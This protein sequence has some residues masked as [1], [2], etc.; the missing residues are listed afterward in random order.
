MTKGDMK[1]KIAS[2]LKENHITCARAMEIAQQNEMSFK[3][4]GDIL[5]DLKVKI[6]KCQLGC[7]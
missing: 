6:K 7:F 1:R 4:M 2:E 3:E 5:N